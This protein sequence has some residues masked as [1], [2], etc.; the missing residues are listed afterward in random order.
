MTLAVDAEFDSLDPSEMTA[1]CWVDIE[2]GAEHD[3]GRDLEDGLRWL[4]GD[5]T[6]V[7]HNGIGF[8]LPAM[9]SL[10]P[11]FKPQRPIVD[12]LVLARMAFADLVPADLEQFG[13]QQEL[14]KIDRRA[15]LG[16]QA[17]HTWGVRLGLAKGE[18]SGE[19]TDGYNAELAEYCLNDC[20][21]TALLYK[22]LLQ[23]NISVPAA[24]LEHK[25]A[26][27]CR[28]IK[29]AGFVF[30]IEGARALYDKLASDIDDV[31]QEMIEQFG[32]WY[33][34]D[35]PIVTPKRSVAYKNKPHT[36]EGCPYQ[37]VK[38]VTFNPNSNAHKAKVLQEQ[39]WQPTDFT[40]TG[41]PKVTGEVLSKISYDYPAA[42]TMARSDKMVKIQGYVRK[43]IEVQRKG[44]IYPDIISIGSRTGRTAS[45]NPNTQQIPS[46]RSTYGKRCRELFKASPG[47]KL[48]AA[49]LDKAELMVLGHYMHPYDGGEYARILSDGDAHQTNADAM[50]ITRDRA[51]AV[52]FAMIY[53]SGDERLGRM[54]GA[55]G[56]TVRRRLLT[57]LPALDTLIKKVRAKAK[58]EGH[59]LSLDRRKIEVD[60]DHKALNY[61]IQ[62]ATSCVAKYWAVRACELTA[63]LECDLVLYVHDELQFDC[64][65]DHIDEASRAITQALREANDYF[66]LRAPMTCEVQV[67]D[68][69]AESH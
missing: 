12:T 54:A 36:Q 20:R 34:P 50:G 51:K 25:F 28:R 39:G 63:H 3:C 2:T 17:L 21:V 53:G 41:A 37:K 67:G 19:W 33:E 32:A 42:A 55:D 29:D 57:A 9:Q 18:Y 24:E 27:V 64:A 7:F 1:L 22:K 8:D 40:N 31:E 5:H 46:A 4:M 30:D 13:S 58:K 35:G 60:S 66:K 48:L 59:I 47:R 26:H 14:M 11:W 68:N 56:K 10:Y 69:W 65:V 23:E 45:Q 62:S 15:R 6:L 38:L 49:D 61:L 43:W 52:A 16:S 44:R